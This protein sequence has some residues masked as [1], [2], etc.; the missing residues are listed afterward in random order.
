MFDYVG[1]FSAAITPRSDDSEIYK[2]REAKLKR[3]FTNA[4]ALYW[5][6]IGKDDFLY[7][8][9]EALRKEFDD[10]GLKYVYHESDGGH[11][12]KNWRAYLSTFAPML[13]R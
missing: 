9:N 2:H 6:G 8:E 12:W 1:L 4:P 10:L 3:Q 13:F 11:I 7:A 5:I